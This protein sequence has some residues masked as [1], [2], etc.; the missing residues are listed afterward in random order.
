MVLVTAKWGWSQNLAKVFA[1]ELRT[2]ESTLLSYAQGP[3]LRVTIGPCFLPTR[4]PDTCW[5]PPKG[6]APVPLRKAHY[7]PEFK[8]WGLCTART[9]GTSFL[10][11]VTCP[12]HTSI[13]YWTQLWF[14]HIQ[15]FI[16]CPRST[17]WQIGA[18]A[19]NLKDTKPQSRDGSIRVC[20]DERKK[21]EGKKLRG[22]K[23]S[24]KK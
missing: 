3:Y 14:S 22:K 4:S 24:E 5:P 20:L 8:V 23:L 12:F 1:V 13:K 16:H 17:P 9:N 7:R 6:H 15:L 2:P 21:L 10:S 18:H 19:S 11:K